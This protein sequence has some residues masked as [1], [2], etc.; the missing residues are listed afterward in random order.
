MTDMRRMMVHVPHSGVRTPYLSSDI[1]TVLKERGVADVRLVRVDATGFVMCLSTSEGIAVDI[2]KCA[3][4]DDGSQPWFCARCDGRVVHFHPHRET[5]VPVRIVADDA[6]EY[7]PASFLLQWASLRCPATEDEW[8]A[9]VRARLCATHVRIEYG[10]MLYY[11]PNVF[12][13]AIL[14][15]V[16]RTALQKKG[17]M[18]GNGAGA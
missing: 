10:P 7:S 2:W 18:Q 16:T 12:A 5:R 8:I 11:E 9:L 15:L 3:P 14:L 6:Y 13:E 4:S 17:D 1:V